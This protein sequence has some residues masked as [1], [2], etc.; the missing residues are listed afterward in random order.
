MVTKTII[1]AKDNVLVSQ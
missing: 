1:Q